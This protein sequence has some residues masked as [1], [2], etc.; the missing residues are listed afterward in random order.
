MCIR[1]SVRG[2]EAMVP[3]L[4]RRLYGSDDLFP[5]TLPDSYRPYQGV[6]FVTSHDGFT[7]YDLV[8]YNEKHNEANGHENRDG[9]DDNRSWNHGWEGNAYVPLPSMVPGPVVVG[10]VPVFM[11]VGLVVFLV[12]GHKVVEGETVVRGNEVH[13]LIRTVR[14]GKRVGK[15]I[16]AAVETPHQCRH[17][18]LITANAVSYTHLTLPTI[19]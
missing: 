15:Q 13:T 14:V 16:V 17:H 1:D 19:L 5:D 18:R 2:D 8:S 12:V 6:N 3:T 9:A 7:L 4:M 11:T 10:T